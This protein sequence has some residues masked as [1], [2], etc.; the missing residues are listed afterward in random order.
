MTTPDGKLPSEIESRIEEADFNKKLTQRHVALEFIHGDRPFYNVTKMK[1][2]LDSD[3]DK[4]TVRTRLNELHER[5]V[6]TREQLNNGNVY[7]LNSEESSW[8][9]PPDV[10]V[11]PERQEPTVSEWKKKPHIRVA[12]VSV[13]I[14]IIGTAVTLIGVFGSSGYYELPVAGTNIIAMGL[15][16][17]IFSYLGLLIAGLLWFIDVPELEEPI[18]LFKT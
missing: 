6:L 3:A 12:A 10:D 5:D 15:S 7:W 4:D 16:A 8:P 18:E 1:A 13:L 11:E 2:A 17:G 9:I 14:A